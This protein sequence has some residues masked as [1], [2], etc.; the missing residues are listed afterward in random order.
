MELKAGAIS[1]TPSTWLTQLGDP[2]GDPQRLH[3]TQII[4][5]PKLL[6]HMNDWSW[7]I[8]HNFLNP[9]KQATAGLSEPQAQH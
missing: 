3:P 6:F 5:P 1:E 2:L 7:L 4:S 8:L 9:I